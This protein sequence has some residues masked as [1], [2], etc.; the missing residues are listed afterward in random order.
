M[1]VPWRG[2]SGRAKWLAIFA[3]TFSLSLGMCGLNFAGVMRFALPIG[4]GPA[5]GTPLDPLWLRILQ[6]VLGIGAPLELVGMAVSL[7]G[8]V[9]CLFMDHGE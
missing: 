3:T 7:V 9:A 8:L 6:G 4:P 5:P 2:K 1:W